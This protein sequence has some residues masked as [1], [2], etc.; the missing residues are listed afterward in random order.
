MFKSTFLSIQIINFL[1]YTLFLPILNAQSANASSKVKE[2]SLAAFSG[3]LQNIISIEGGSFS[4]GCESD[5]QICDEDEKPAHRIKL[6]AFSLG[7][8]EVSIAEFETFLLATGYQTD[9]AKGLDFFNGVHKLNGDAFTTQEKKVYPICL[10]SYFDAKA[11]CDWLK[12]ETGLPFRLPTEA[13]WEYA[14]RGGAK[15]KNT[16]FA[17]GATLQDVGWYKENS[18]CEIQ[19]SGAKKPNELGLY[20]MSGNVWEWCSDRYME[21]YYKISEKENPQGPLSGTYRV[22][23]G[24]CWDCE[25]KTCSV[26]YRGRNTPDFRSF[27]VGFRVAMTGHIPVQSNEPDKNS[28][29]KHVITK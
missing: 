26:T 1:V 16:I 8:Y 18:N 22:F 19:A 25:E 4:M 13:E 6:D 27:I 12:K 20:D 5:Q 21:T 14:A 29:R 7:K 3:T 24:G 17:G 15:S 2:N 9:A 28:E 23:R 11:Y 10:V